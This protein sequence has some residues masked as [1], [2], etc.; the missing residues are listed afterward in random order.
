MAQEE[1]QNQPNQDH[2]NQNISV[3]TVQVNIDPNRISIDDDTVTQADLILG[4]KNHLQRLMDGEA[5]EGEREEEE[6]GG[7]G[8]G[9][10]VAQ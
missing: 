3:E 4:K 8:R 2:S 9:A 10:P 6:G 5:T 1:D 7:S